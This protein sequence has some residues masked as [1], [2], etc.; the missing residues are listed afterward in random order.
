MQP[1]Y[2]P[3]PYTVKRP[4]RGFLVVLAAFVVLV[5]VA[6]MMRTGD[7]GEGEREQVRGGAPASEMNR[8]SADVV[9]TTG[10]DRPRATEDNSGPAAVVPPAIIQELSTITGTVDGHELIGRRVNVHATIQGVANDVAFWAGEG[11]NRI[12]V[13]TARDSRDG[14]SRQRGEPS[15][16]G[17][18]RLEAGRQVTITGTLQRLPKAEEMYS[19]QLSRNEAAELIDRKIYLRADTVT[20]Q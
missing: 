11:D 5:V 17:I 10:E 15:S 13:V 3:N 7:A 14:E 19:W 6:V 9:G 1:D 20:Q 4:R 12:F 18:P 16:H 2:Q 8:G